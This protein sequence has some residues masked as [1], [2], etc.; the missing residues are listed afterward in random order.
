M[1]TIKLKNLKFYGHHGNSDAEIIVGHQ[2]EADVEIRTSLKI[3]AL[4]DDLKDA[5]N[6]A[7][8]YEI[9][10][11]TIT[12]T[13]YNL[14]EKLCDQICLKILQRYP[15]VSVKVAI[16]KPLPPIKGI[17]DYVEVEMTRGPVQ[18]QAMKSES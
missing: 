13:K 1:D 9:M 2:F 18:D 10:A 17:L 8:V 16:R 6:Y 3:A 11:E 12:G 15:G 4:S 7:E 5:V 14:L